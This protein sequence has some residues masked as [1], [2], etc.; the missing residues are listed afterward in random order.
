MQIKRHISTIDTIKCRGIIRVVNSVVPRARAESDCQLETVSPNDFTMSKSSTG[1]VLITGA[2]GSCAI[3]FI[4]HIKNH[5]PNLDIIATVRNA[6]S[7]DPNT[8]YLSSIIPPSSIE[9]LDLSSLAAVNTFTAGLS[10]RIAEGDLPHLKAVVCNAFTMSLKDQIFTSD[11]LEQTFQVNHL[12]H[13]LLVLKLLGSMASDGRIVML[14][15]NAHYTGRKHPL[16]DIPVS[17]PDDIGKLVK[18]ER[19]TPGNEYSH[20]FQRY[21]VSKLANIIF[22]HDLNA[23]LAKVLPHI[24]LHPPY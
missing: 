1:T 8:A 2:N 10:R 12:A 20:G 17:I 14:G 19:D 7:D 13:Y 24:S 22:M 16:F 11:G 9:A 15:S 5:Y 21:G 6:S 18:P 23:R 4:S 3:P